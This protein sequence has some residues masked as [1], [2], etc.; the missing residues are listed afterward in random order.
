MRRTR[1]DS[2]CAS[3]EYSRALSPLEPSLTTI[4][5][6]EPWV[7]PRTELIARLSRTGRFLDGMMTEKSV[8][9]N[10]AFDVPNLEFQVDLPSASQRQH[11]ADGE[12]FSWRTWRAIAVQIKSVGYR[13]RLRL[14]SAGG[15]RS[16]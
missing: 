3:W 11:S 10:V 7:C 15:S 4:T 9:I 5:S 8:G 14:K 1:S 16:L 12:M 13:L 2:S 6:T